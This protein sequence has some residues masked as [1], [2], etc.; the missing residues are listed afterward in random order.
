[1]HCVEA[2]VRNESSQ[3]CFTYSDGLGFPVDIPHSPP[4]HVMKTFP[5]TFTL[6]AIYFVFSPFVAQTLGM[7]I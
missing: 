4:I 3:V 2:Q 6:L 5:D 7:K 1:M